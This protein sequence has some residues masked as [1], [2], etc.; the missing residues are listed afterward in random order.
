MQW[1]E[2]NLANLPGVEA[3]LLE[4]GWKIARVAAD[5][6]PKRSGAGAKSIHPELVK[7]GGVPEVHISWD[8]HHFYMLFSEIGTQHELA[9]PFLR[10]AAARFR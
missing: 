6:A 9:R 4:D 5:L 1:Q 7:V 2:P 10:P 8:R 3:A